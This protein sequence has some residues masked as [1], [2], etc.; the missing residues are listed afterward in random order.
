MNEMIICEKC[1]EPMVSMNKDHT[2]GMTCSKCGWGWVTQHFNPIDRDET[3]YSIFIKPGNSPTIDNIKLISP[4]SATN[5]IEAKNII[6]AGANICIYKLPT[7][8]Q[9]I[10]PKQERLGILLLY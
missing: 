7:N 5:F 1:G 6:K 8:L 2:A 3:V 10:I 4:L 9:L